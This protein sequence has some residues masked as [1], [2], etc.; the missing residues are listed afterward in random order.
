MNIP[1]ITIDLSE[2]AV[3]IIDSTIHILMACFVNDLVR[4]S[5]ETA[6]AEVLHIDH[7]KIGRKTVFRSEDM[8]ILIHLS[9]K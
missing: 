5:I 8:Q 6:L 2:C 9:V 7:V 1:I 3:T 4:S